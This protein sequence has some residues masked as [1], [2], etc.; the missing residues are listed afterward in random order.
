MLDIDPILSVPD[1]CNYTHC[2]GICSV[3]QVYR[4]PSRGRY[5]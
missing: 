5:L 3:P 4:S 2:I 1:A